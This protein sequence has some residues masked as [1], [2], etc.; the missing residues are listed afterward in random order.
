MFVATTV[1]CCG[2]ELNK[3]RMTAE[4]S[5]AEMRRPL[6]E[7]IKPHWDETAPSLL[8]Y[9]Q[10]EA[11]RRG[12]TVRR[13][14]LEARGLRGLGVGGWVCALQAVSV[15]RLVSGGGNQH[16]ARTLKVHVQAHAR[17]PQYVRDA[18]GRA[19]D[20]AR[21]LPPPRFEPTPPL[22]LLH[23]RTQDQPPS[24]LRARI[25]TCS[26]SPPPRHCSAAF[27]HPKS[28]MTTLWPRRSRTCCQGEC[29]AATWRTRT[30]P[31]QASNP[32]RAAPRRAPIG[33][34]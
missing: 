15:R 6:E 3:L 21:S 33:A 9:L 32:R 10:D 24:A 29:C 1:P 4:L 16:E 5:D 8:T 17:L 20:A 14:L 19:G 25:A 30:C 13:E 7:I 22:P 11:E 23:E 28:P 31:S 26:S 2:S 18:E 34:S 12:T 27:R